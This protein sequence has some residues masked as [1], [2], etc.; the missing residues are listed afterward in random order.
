M[1]NCKFTFRFV[2]LLIVFISAALP[3]FG[4]HHNRSQARTCNVRIYAEA[5]LN[6]SHMLAE[7]LT[8][9]YEV[10]YETHYMPGYHWMCGIQISRSPFGLATGIGY[11]SLNL[12]YEDAVKPKDEI[13]IQSKSIFRLNYWRLPIIFIFDI[14]PKK[15]LFIT[16]S[17]E[18]CWLVNGIYHTISRHGIRAIELHRR[19][20]P[21]ADFISIGFG[22][23]IN[24]KTSISFQ[25]AFIPGND[26]G[27]VIPLEGEFYD[28]Y[29]SSKNVIEFRIGFTYE[30]FS[31]KF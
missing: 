1:M 15:K 23:Y 29:T 5:G 4:Q 9:K 16:T 2:L 31:K 17:Y 26:Y 12:N 8:D 25:T 6:L 19:F 30:L 28:S 7:G 3:A 27:K 20:D 22:G 14:L 18:I 24:N 21:T 11:K 10:N 13:P